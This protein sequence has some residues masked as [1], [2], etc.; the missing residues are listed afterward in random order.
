VGTFVLYEDMCGRE[1]FELVMGLLRS[2]GP[3]NFSQ[4]A[5]RYEIGES[6]I[7]TPQGKVGAKLP[8]WRP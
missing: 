4:G 2:V 5:V 3:E 1:A 8:T 7:R 6:D